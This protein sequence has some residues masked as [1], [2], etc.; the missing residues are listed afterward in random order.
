MFKTAIVSFLHRSLRGERILGAR[1]RDLLHA[2]GEAQERRPPGLIGTRLDGLSSR[3]FIGL[4]M[5]PDDSV[6]GDDG[7]RHRL[8]ERADERGHRGLVFLRE[9]ERTDWMAVR[10]L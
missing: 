10:D 8:A 5:G 7:E 6:R 4:A 3:I 1:A 9:G 2:G